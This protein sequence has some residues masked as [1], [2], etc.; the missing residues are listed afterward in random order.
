VAVRIVG[1]VK[2][3]K[4]EHLLAFTF[5]WQVMMDAWFIFL[6]LPLQSLQ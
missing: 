4:R 1:P 5:K 2:A 3:E 6:Y